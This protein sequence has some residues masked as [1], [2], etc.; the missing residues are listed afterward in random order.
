M[1][2]DLVRIHPHLENNIG[3][4]GTRALAESLKQNTTLTELDFR[5]MLG[6]LLIAVR[7]DVAHNV[8]AYIL[9]MFRQPN[10]Q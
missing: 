7:L 3:D 2:H 8:C 5:S 4:E 10:W 9:L 6:L 1:V